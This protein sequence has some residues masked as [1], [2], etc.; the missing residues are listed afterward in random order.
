[1][2]AEAADAQPLRDVHVCFPGPCTDTKCHGGA[3]FLQVVKGVKAASG[4]ESVERYGLHLKCI[5]SRIL[6][7]AISLCSCDADEPGKADI[8][9][10]P[11]GDGSDY[12]LGS[13]L[14]A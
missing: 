2:A 6:C 14:T 1:M 9:L 7:Q 13:L 4:Y 11:L 5:G 10:L 3:D 12:S 8:T